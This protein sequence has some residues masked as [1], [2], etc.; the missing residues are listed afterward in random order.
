MLLVNFFQW[1]Y[2]K[3]WLE[4]A[5][6]TI[7]RLRY[8]AQLFSVSILLRTLFAPWK[9]ITTIPG[10]S[11]G[12]KLRATLD[13]FVSRIIGFLTRTIVIIAALI[14]M[15]IT[16]IGGLVLFIVWPFAPFIAIFLIYR[17]FV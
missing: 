4:F 10:K 7:D 6:K 8:L 16:A 15:F 12:E 11:I 14:V 3:G 9:R 5:K 13:N 1:W 2:T 17:A